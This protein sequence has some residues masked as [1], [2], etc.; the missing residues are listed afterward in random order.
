[1]RG[2]RAA[3]WVVA[4]VLLASCSGGGGA[5]D[6][7]PA[8]LTTPTVVPASAPAFER[9]AAERLAAQGVAWA[10]ACDRADPVQDA[11]LRAYGAVLVAPVTVTVPPRCRFASAA[12]ASAFQSGLAVRTEELGGSPV[13]L[14]AAA[15]ADLLEAADQLRADGRELRPRSADAAARTYDQGVALWSDRVGSGLTAWR[16]AGRLSSDEAARIRGLAPED[17]VADVLRLEAEGLWF[18]THQEGPILESV[19]PPGSSQHL[20]LLAFDVAADTDPAVTAAMAANGWFRTA[21]GDRPH[22]TYLG[23]AEGDL[24]DHGLR[25]DDVDGTTYWVPDL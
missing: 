25:R 20:G 5:G 1:M 19:A 4:S 3:P 24:A 21:R 7:G 17:Q 13:R 14:Q 22:F 11:V 16:R 2:T 18:G 10:D 8:G 9:A 23:W 6:P 15:M 12:E